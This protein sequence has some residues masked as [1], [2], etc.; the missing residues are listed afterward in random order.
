MVS[1][2]DAVIARLNKGEDHF[3]ILVD[4]YKA[5]DVIE[6][7]EENIAQI[8]AIDAI[9]SDSKKG[10]HASD[11]SLEK[12]FGT[13]EV[14]SIAKEIILHGDIRLTTEQRNKMQ[15]NKKKRV[16]EY[17]MKNAC[18]DGLCLPDDSYKE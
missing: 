8:M 15:Q 6:G 4:P 12:H 7:K 5:S 16:I 3:E 9:F 18:V 14:E 11:E 1:L 17:I 2:D 10:T 13:T